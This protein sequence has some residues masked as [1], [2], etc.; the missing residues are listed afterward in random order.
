MG[1]H[2]VPQYYLKGFS[3][4]DDDLLWV[5]EKGIGCRFNAKIKNI[6]NITK[7]YSPKVEQYLANTIEEPANKI[8]E[9]IRKRHKISEDDKK[10]FAEY[11]A[12]MW[13][14]VPRGKERLKKIAPKVSQK[15]SKELNRDLDIIASQGLTKTSLIKKSRVKIKEILDKYAKNPPKEIWLNNILFKRNPR[16]IAAVRAMNWTFLTFDEKPVFLTCDNPVFYF[17]DIGIGNPESEITFPISSKITLWATWRNDLPQDY[18]QTTKQVVKEIN[19]RTAHNASRYIFH[20]RD[21]HWIESFI[22]KHSWQL[23]KLR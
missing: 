15:L 21:E 5:Y 20:G 11:V 12:V 22:K 9:K 7:F 23:H 4:S 6:G 8:L 3:E 16:I 19:R 1:H 18:I 14:R 13:K 10:I 2:Y 17:T